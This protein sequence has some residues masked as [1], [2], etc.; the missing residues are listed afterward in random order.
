MKIN[1]NILSFWEKN[2]KIL[3][4]NMPDSRLG[5]TNIPYYYL[6][7]NLATTIACPNIS[8]KVMVY[9]FEDFGW[10]SEEVAL[11]IIKI[12]SFI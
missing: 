3:V 2:H 7:N 4:I 5:I 9:Y 6:D 10:V 1:S 12:F 8:G 11:R